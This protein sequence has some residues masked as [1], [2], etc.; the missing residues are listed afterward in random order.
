[1]QILDRNEEEKQ[2]KILIVPIR[3]CLVLR[4]KDAPRVTA[5]E[6]H[7]LKNECS[8]EIKEELTCLY[9]VS[10]LSQESERK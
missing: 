4:T 2:V 6:F 5:F 3:D 9:M 1:M 10:L 7:N 8:W